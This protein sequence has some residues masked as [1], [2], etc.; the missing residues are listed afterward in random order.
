MLVGL[1]HSVAV[2]EIQHRAAAAS[3]EAA[4]EATVQLTVSPDH[5]NWTYRLGE[6]VNFRF[7][8][9]QGGKPVGSVPIVYRVG[10][11]QMPAQERSAVI[12]ADGLTVTGGTL[13][14]PGFLRCV[15]TAEVAGHAVR[16]MATVAYAPEAITPTQTEP[17]DFDAFWRQAKSELEKAPM[18]PNLSLVPE[19][20]TETVD[21]YR[22]DFRTVGPTWGPVPPRIYGMLCEPKSPGKYPAVLRLPGA[23]ARPYQGDRE[24]ASHGIITLEIGIHGIPVNLPAEAYLQLIVGGLNGYWLFNLDNPSA[25]YFW[26]V[27]LS[28]LRAND[29]LVGRPKWNGKDLLTV[30]ASQ[31]GQLAIVTAVL[32]SRVTGL[33]A[34][35]PAYCDVTGELH[36][37]AGGWPRPFVAWSTA[38]Q[39]AS[40]IPSK[41]ATTG[42][43]DTVNFARRLKVPGHY[44]WGYNDETCAP[45]SL[46]A[47]YNTITAPKELRLMLELGHDYR[48]EMG[49]DMLDWILRYLALK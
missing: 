29:F 33:A 32:D 2:A 30:G 49:A 26:R 47:A 41:V 36:G 6:P 23:G 25:Y 40:G 35:H 39:P 45:I 37:R 4:R 19:A 21:V 9:T 10:P 44:L 14:E 13:T 8:V 1:L 3:F 31:G 12:P 22:V 7:A 18:E 34:T 15:V 43:Y 20:C 27:Y 17:A 42:Y 16:G 5:Q 24:L 38:M 11:E 48:P 28:C 46:Y